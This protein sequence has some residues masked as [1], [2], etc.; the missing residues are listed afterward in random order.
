MS[1]KFCMEFT[2][3]LR[4]AGTRPLTDRFVATSIIVRTFLKSTIFGTIFGV[5][6][7]VALETCKGCHDDVVKDRL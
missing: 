4:F 5:T 6:R 1:H 3:I 7:V 2:P